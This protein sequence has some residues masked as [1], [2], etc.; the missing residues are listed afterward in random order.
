MNY[1]LV[2]NGVVTNIIWLH[3]MN[4]NDFQN[5]VPTN[6]LPIQIGDTYTK[7]KFYRDGKE[8]VSVHTGQTYTLDEAA[9]LLAQEVSQ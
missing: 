9:T 7:G 5:A 1:A 3:P 8:I 2:E 6:D 4:A